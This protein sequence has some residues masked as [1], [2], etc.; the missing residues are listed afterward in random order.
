M[1][2]VSSLNGKITNGDDSS[3]YKWT[4]KEDQ[5]FFEKL[6]DGNILVMGSKT[7]EAAKSIIKPTSSRRRIVLTSDPEKYKDIAVEGQLE[8][9]N[10]SPKQL[11]DR[12]AKYNEQ[13]LLVGGGKLN[14]SFLNEGLVDEMYLTIEPYVFSEGKPLVEGLGKN[15]FLELESCERLNNNGTLLLKYKVLK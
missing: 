3:I 1:V 6:K 15:V 7:Y 5:S 9:S 12:L 2:M 10:E 14:A 8:F 13:M 4:S 11:V